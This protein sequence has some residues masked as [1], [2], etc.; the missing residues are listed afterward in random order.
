[1]NSRGWLTWFGAALALTAS[2]AVA[3]PPWQKVAIFKKIE[4]DPDKAYPLTENQGPWVIMAIT[5]S[6]KE[7]EAAETA[8]QVHEL[9]FELRSR[10]K[11]EA[12]TY[13]FVEDLNVGVKVLGVDRFGDPRRPKYRHDQVHE[14]AVVVGNFSAVDDP[15][16]QRV[17]KKLKHAKPDCLNVDKL[18]KQGKHDH[19]SFGLLRHVQSEF[20]R[21]LGNDQADFG[22][23]GH[24]F[25]TTN[26]LLPKEYFVPKG[27]DDF[28]A[29]MNEPVEFSLLKCPGKYTCKIATFEG[30]VLIEQDKI[31]QVEEGAKRLAGRLEA[32]A[33]QAHQMTVA[34]RAKGYEAYEFHDRNASMV[35]VESF[36]SVGTP[37]A[38]GQMEMNP[39]LLKIIETFSAEKKIVPGRQPQIGTPKSIVGIPFDIQAIPIEVPSRSVGARYAQR[40]L[41]LQ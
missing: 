38:D 4:C 5:F 35:T 18:A 1:M 36:D 41:R 11:I 21:Q 3:A 24:A 26:P 22:P 13:E 27:L 31:R 23:M 9:V 29:R 8:K 28:V 32:A 33:L 30:A 12:Y 37:R 7:D 25:I 10:F 19:R 2:G 15:E 20:N 17:L 40:S 34:L 6:P 16:A 14:I 39:K